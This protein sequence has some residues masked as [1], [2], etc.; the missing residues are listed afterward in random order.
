MVYFFEEAIKQIILPLILGIFLLWF[1]KRKRKKARE[2]NEEHKLRY[3]KE[4]TLRVI[5]VDKSERDEWVD[6]D[7]PDH[8]RELVHSVTY[9]PVYE[10]TVNGQ[11]YEYHTRLGNSSGY[12]IGAEC[13]GYY[14]PKNPSDVTETV[15][16]PFAS[17][18]IFFGGV[19]SIAGIGC[20]VYAA[21]VLVNSL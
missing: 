14:N 10:Y 21:F 4:T 1:G 19:A 8:S 13:T 6:S 9:T 11:R 2:A 17:S 3:T 5:A 18:D 15:H 20:M 16:D 7:D 12:Q